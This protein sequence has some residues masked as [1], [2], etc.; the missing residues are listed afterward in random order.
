MIETDAAQ[1]HGGFLLAPGLGDD[2]D[3]LCAI[4][5]R[6]RPRGVLAAQPD[7]DATGDVILGILGG[8]ADVE[9]LSA[10]VSHP[11]DLVEIDRDGEPV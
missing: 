3:G 10:R 2:H 5:H 1:A 6:A 4:E 11:K 8:I 9:N 7:V